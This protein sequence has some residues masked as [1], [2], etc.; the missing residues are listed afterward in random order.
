MEE[1]LTKEE[2]YIEGS[3]KVKTLFPKLE[4]LKLLYLP[5]LECVCS[6]NYDYDIMVS[7]MEE[8]REINKSNNNNIQISFPELKVLELRG[9]PKLK[10]FCSGAYDYDIMV[11]SMEECLNMGTFPH[12][13]V[14]HAYV[15]CVQV[16]L[17]K[18]KTF[19]DIDKVL[20]EYIKG[21]TVLE[22]VNCHKLQKCIPSNMMH[23]FLHLKDLTVGECDFLDEIFESNDCML[24]LQCE[25]W[26]LNLFS[27]PKLKHI[28]KNRGQILGFKCLKFIIVK[29]C[30]DLEYVFPDVTMVTSLPHLLHIDVRQ[31]EK[32]K[33]I[34]GNNCVQ[35]KANKI[36]F[37]SLRFIELKNLPNLKCFGQSSLPSYVELPEFHNIRIED[38]QELKTFWDDGIVYTRNFIISMDGSYFD[39]ESDLN[40]FIQQHSKLQ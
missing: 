9:V 5:K 20:L 14:I 21:V 30:N 16:E 19:K 31:C 7:S 6:G 28:W 3:N 4:E 34:I 36:I 37:P 25:L 40:E 15:C 1:I 10:C 27:L 22:I 38:C 35:Q 33:E 24:M 11:S 23:L 2:E 18:L 13:N 17:Q 29:Q 8:D 26:S 39:D 32:M 12:G